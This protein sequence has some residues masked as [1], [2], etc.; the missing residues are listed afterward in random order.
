MSFFTI[1]H[2]RLF[3]ENESVITFFKNNNSVLLN[4]EKVEE[5]LRQAPLSIGRQTRKRSTRLT[6]FIAKQQAIFRENVM[7]RL[8]GNSDRE[9]YLELESDPDNTDA[10]FIFN[11]Q[12][13]RI[14][15]HVVKEEE[16]IQ[17]KMEQLYGIILVKKG[18]C[19]SNPILYTIIQCCSIEPQFI[20][21]LISVAV[22]IVKT[23]P[24]IVFKRILAYTDNDYRTDSY[25]AFGFVQDNNLVCSRKNRV[26]M[27]S[28]L[29][30]ISTENIISHGISNNNSNVSV[31]PI[32]SIESPKKQVNE[33]KK[34]VKELIAKYER[35]IQSYKGG[36]KKRTR[37]RRKRK[38]KI[39]KKTK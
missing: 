10:L 32:N 13:K 21:L 34:T 26:T 17:Y 3:L 18:E 14:P 29:D 4:K 1:E 19:T 23:T 37:R 2:V 9:R 5:Y 16:F 35:K 33:T 15:S 22:F 12:Y 20:P 6:N 27:S 11:N 25:N 28:E 31:T 36:H 24:T 7:T 30:V 38:N 39:P 8:C